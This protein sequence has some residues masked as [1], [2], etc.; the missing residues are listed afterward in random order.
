M[1]I[2]IIV[3]VFT[4]AWELLLESAIYILFGL[5][6][7]GLLKV[8]LPADLI[9]RHLGRGRFK[10]V[11]KA[12]LLGIPIPLCS[13]GV[14]PTAMSLR[15]QGAGKGATTAFLISTPESGVDSI[16][17]SYA[18]LGP[19]M[20]VARPVSAFVTAAVAGIAENLLHKK[21]PQTSS[22]E[23]SFDRSCPVDGC[24]DGTDCEPSQHRR[25]HSHGVKIA[26][27]MRYALR[28]FWNDLAVW[29]FLGLLMAGIIAAVM[30]A[31]VFSRYIGPG[32]PTM[33]AMLAIGIP[34]YICATAST[35]IAAALILKGLSP[36]AALVF[37]MAGP[38]TNMATLTVLLAIMGK[39][40][41]GIYLAAIAICSISMGL[42]LDLLL[43]AGH[44]PVVATTAEQTHLMPHWVELGAA[45]LLLALS[46]K[47]ISQRL[48]RSFKRRP[49]QRAS[50]ST[51][52]P[53]QP[54]GCGPT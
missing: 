36:G 3:A 24:C 46:V 7:S 37:L 10:S 19:V 41:T 25:H 14:L 54:P 45:L 8:Y 17:V 1:D 40:A 16:A 5:I 47:P 31:D 32:L 35:P 44:V 30:P 50:D 9:A 11:F 51:A 29:F 21:E 12:A 53:V 22:R 4:A 49:R 18:L 23:L 15:K 34:L 2:H 33:L 39:R 43:T 38:A 20:A 42:S 26:A 13:C 6:I 52:T 27:G 28:D 48:R